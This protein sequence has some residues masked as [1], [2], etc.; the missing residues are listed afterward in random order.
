MKIGVITKI[1]T[2]R[3]LLADNLLHVENCERF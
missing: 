1:G 2:G 3:K